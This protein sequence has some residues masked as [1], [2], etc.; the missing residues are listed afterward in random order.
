MASLPQ[1]TPVDRHGIT[2]VDGE[3]VTLGGEYQGKLAVQFRRI[4]LE[5]AGLIEP[6]GPHLQEQLAGIAAQGEHETELAAVNGAQCRITPPLLTYHQQGVILAHQVA[7]H[8]QQLAIRVA[9]AVIHFPGR[10]EQRGAVDD[11]LSHQIDGAQER[12]QRHSLA[13]QQ[14]VVAARSTGQRQYLEVG[15][16]GLIQHALQQGSGLAG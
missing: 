6:G 16:L 11:P 14:Q 4:A 5:V 10:P 13:Q 7:A 8:Q 12:L 3:G 2:G 1:G 9:G 15:P